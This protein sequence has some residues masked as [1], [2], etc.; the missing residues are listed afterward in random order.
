VRA[1]FA[2]RRGRM[3]VIDRRWRAGCGAMPPICGCGGPGGATGH[4]ARRGPPRPCGSRTCRRSGSE[5]GTSLLH[6][7]HLR[8]RPPAGPDAGPGGWSEAGTGV[9]RARPA[10]VPWA[11]AASAAARPSAPPSAAAPSD[12]PAACRA[13]AEP[14]RGGAAGLRSRAARPAATGPIGPD[15]G[16]GPAARRERGPIGTPRHAGSEPGC[17]IGHHRL[18]HAHVATTRRLRRGRRLCSASEAELV[19]ILVF[20]AAAIT[21]DHAFSSGSSG[22]GPNQTIS[23]RSS[24]C[25]MK[26]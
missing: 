12:P 21:D 6:D 23:T 7:G 1:A 19:V 10:A 3:S 4:L 11:A 9:A 2:S 14:P 20:L 25:P 18:H 17:G 13:R 15:I 22:S 26:T 16:I 5:G 24:C 8:R